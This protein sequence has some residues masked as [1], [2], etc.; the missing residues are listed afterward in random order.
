MPNLSNECPLK[1][2]KAS[3][4]RK[5]YI[6][7]LIEMVFVKYF[8]FVQFFSIGIFLFIFLTIV[9]CSLQEKALCDLETC[10]TCI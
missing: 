2:K 3:R 4:V 9:H 10:V 6:C 1:T 5:P 8:F 7:C